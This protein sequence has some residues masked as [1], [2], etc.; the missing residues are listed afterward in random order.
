MSRGYDH[1]SVTK[2]QKIT[3]AHTTTAA[4]DLKRAQFSP[5]CEDPWRQSE[6]EQLFLLLQGTVAL[7]RVEFTKHSRSNWNL[8]TGAMFYH[9][10][11]LFKG[12]ARLPHFLLLQNKQTRTRKASWPS[13]CCYRRA[14]QSQNRSRF[15]FVRRN[16]AALQHSKPSSSHKYCKTKS[17]PETTTPNKKW[18]KTEWMG[19]KCEASCGLNLLRCSVSCVKKFKR[20]IS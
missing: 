20:N 10:T 15:E 13:S 5:K 3:A 11:T 6:R 16:D 2:F 7:V 4:A 8:T 1:S 9:V 12:L 19:S 18:S 17:S 14:Q